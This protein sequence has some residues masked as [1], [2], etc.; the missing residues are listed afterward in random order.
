MVP[1][2]HF[3]STLNIHRSVHNHLSPPYIGEELAGVVGQLEHAET[4]REA[5]ELAGAAG[6]GASADAG[7]AEEGAGV[8]DG[9]FGGG[10]VDGDDV[11]VGEMDVE[12]EL[13]VEYWSK[14]ANDVWEKYKGM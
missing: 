6:L 13:G 7:G 9:H 11:R 2:Q 10:V 8:E 3:G 1:P 14:L 5:E 12:D 4:S